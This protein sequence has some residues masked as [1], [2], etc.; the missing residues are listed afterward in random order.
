MLWTAFIYKRMLFFMS[1][2]RAGLFCRI[3]ASSID[4]LEGAHVTAKFAIQ[5][6]SQYE[7]QIFG[8]HWSQKCNK[9]THSIKTF[10]NIWLEKYY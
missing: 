6:G 8:L 7:N 9:T 10:F 2:K 5:N 1:C 4:G 3:E